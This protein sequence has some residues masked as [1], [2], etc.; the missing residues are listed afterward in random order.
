MSDAGYR[1]RILRLRRKILLV[2]GKKSLSI[3]CS[4]FE[5]FQGVANGHISSVG[6][7]L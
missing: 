6:K 5:G 1:R 2:V 7:H 4:V 3:P